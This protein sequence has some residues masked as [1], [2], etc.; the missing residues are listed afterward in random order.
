MAN[1]FPDPHFWSVTVA[2]TVTIAMLLR[3]SP[4]RKSNSR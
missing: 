3:S 2:N 1:S 4:N